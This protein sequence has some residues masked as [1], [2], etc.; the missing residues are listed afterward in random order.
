MSHDEKA[1]VAGLFRF[2]VSGGSACCSNNDVDDDDQ[3]YV[4]NPGHR[5]MTFGT[6]CELRTFNTSGTAEPRMRTCCA[7]SSSAALA[8]DRVRE[9]LA[10]D[11]LTEFGELPSAPFYTHHRTNVEGL[12]SPVSILNLKHEG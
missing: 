1:V 12:N 7:T 3:I 11:L 6:A 8:R 10:V 5:F 9:S 4:T 2:L